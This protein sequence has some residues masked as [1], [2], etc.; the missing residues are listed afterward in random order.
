LFK[1]KNTQ[2]IQCLGKQNPP[3]ENGLNSTL[4]PLSGLSF[5]VVQA[6]VGLG[7]GII[8]AIVIGGIVGLVVIIVLC[9]CCCY[10]CCCKKSQTTHTVVVTQAPGQQPGMA[11]QPATGQPQPPPSY[12]QQVA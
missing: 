5:A 10:H 1:K 3:W 8:V 11:M 4:N 2:T 7:V 12:D 6:A 9:G